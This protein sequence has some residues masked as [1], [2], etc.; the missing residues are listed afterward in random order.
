[1]ATKPPIPKGHVMWIDHLALLPGDPSVKTSLGGKAAA[2]KLIWRCQSADRS[3]SEEEILHFLKIGGTALRRKGLTPIPNW[4]E[5]LIT[6]VAQY[7]QPPAF[8][9]QRYRAQ[10]AG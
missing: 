6:M 10:R 5:T 2:E 1:M 7:F 8:E 4:Q 3:A 9:L